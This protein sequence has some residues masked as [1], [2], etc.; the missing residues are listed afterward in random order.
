VSNISHPSPRTHLKAESLPLS[1]P[2][3]KSTIISETPYEVFEELSGFDAI[4]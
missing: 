2:H 4:M 3:S 1:I